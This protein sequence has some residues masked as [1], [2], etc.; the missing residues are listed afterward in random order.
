MICFVVVCVP[1]DMSHTFVW[2]MVKLGMQLLCSLI[3]ANLNV[4]GLEMVL[5]KCLY[6]AL[7]YMSRKGRPTLFCFSCR[8]VCTVSI[9]YSLHIDGSPVF[10]MG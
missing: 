9:Y 6:F 2:G 5:C 10:R 4:L 7:D 1:I 3:I 8:K